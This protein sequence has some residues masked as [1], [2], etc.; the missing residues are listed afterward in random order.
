MLRFV[1]GLTK[2]HVQRSSERSLSGRVSKFVKG[3]FKS[4][5]PADCLRTM[6]YGSTNNT[7]ESLRWMFETQDKLLLREAL[8]PKTQTLN[9]RYQTLAP[10]DCYIIAD[11]IGNSDCRWRLDFRRCHIPE[12]GM[13]MLAGR[14]SGSLSC[15]ETINLSRTSLGAGGVHLGE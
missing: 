14:T 4:R 9:L 12:T 15:V 2:F 6:Y 10:F 13:R 11:C 3:L 1:A 7:M 8:D 5:G